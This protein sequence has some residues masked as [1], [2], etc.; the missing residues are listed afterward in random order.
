M[1]RGVVDASPLI[2]LGKIQRLE[3]LGKI[4]S[5]VVVPFEVAREVKSGPR[6]DPAALWFMSPGSGVSF[7]SEPNVLPEIEKWDLGKGESAVISF[8]VAGDSSYR[9]ILDDRAGRRCAQVFGI[10]YMGTLGILIRAKN[11]GL[12]D[13]LEKDIF[14]LQSVG[15]NLSPALIQEAL[16]LGN[17]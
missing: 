7:I 8:C 5:E 1:I 14:E 4:F 10:R 11:L 13:D 2:L 6:D 9:A 17:P 15:A 12:I 3:L 16:R